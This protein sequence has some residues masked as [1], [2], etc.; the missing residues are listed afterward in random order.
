MGDN[1]SNRELMKNSQVKTITHHA[2][3]NKNHPVYYFGKLISY[4][5]LSFFWVI[6]PIHH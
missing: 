4:L 5:Y 2:K 3:K 6:S 1:F